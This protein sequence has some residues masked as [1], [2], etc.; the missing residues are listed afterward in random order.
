MTLVLVRHGPTEWSVSGQHTSTTDIPLT[1]RGREAAGELRE[2]LAGREFA[3]VLASPRT[4]ALET[5]HLAG[6]EPEIEPDLAEVDYGDY[7]GRTTPEIRAERPRLVA[8]DRRRARRRD[9]GAGGRAGRPRDR[10]RAGRRRRRRRLRPRP[11]PARA[12]RPLD[13]PPARHGGS[14]ALDTAAVSELGFERERRVI[15]AWNIT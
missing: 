8:V 6:F 1:E 2:R 9:D 7:E 12:R 5:A 11:H 14:F 4:R 3:L 10:P 13:R 15:G